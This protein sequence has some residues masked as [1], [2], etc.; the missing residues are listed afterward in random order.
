MRIKL[1]DTTIVRKTVGIIRRNRYLMAWFSAK[2]KLP[3]YRKDIVRCSK[4]EI[5]IKPDWGGG[6]IRLGKPIIVKR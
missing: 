4:R 6:V 1:F 3:K 2:W 5:T